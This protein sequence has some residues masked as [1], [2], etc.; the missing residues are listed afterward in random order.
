MIVNSLKSARPIFHGAA[1]L[2]SFSLL[3]G[4]FFSPALRAGLLLALHDGQ[5]FYWPNFSSPLTLWTDLIFGGFPIAADPQAQSWYPITRLLALIPDSWNAFMISAYVLASTLAYGYVYALTRSPL[6]A[7]VSGLTFGMSGFMIGHLPHASILH[8]VVWLPLMIWSLHEL[9]RGVSPGWVAAGAVGVALSALAGHPQLLVYCLVLTAA[10]ALVL[11]L[12]G[13]VPRGR[14]FARVAAMFVLGLALAAIQ[15]LPTFEL[16]A[17]ASRWRTD[18][19]MFSDVSLPPRQTI[20]LLFPYAFGGDSRSPYRTEY[21]GAPNQSE[22]A[23]YVG[24][25]P[26]VLAVAGLFAYRRRPV[27]WFWAVVAVLALW[28]AWGAATPLWRLIY[29][30]PMYNKFRAP[31]RHLVEFALAMSVLSGLGVAAILRRSQSHGPTSGDALEAGPNRKAMQRVVFGA[32][33]ILGFG[34]I[35][36][37]IAIGHSGVGERLRGR[38]AEETLLAHP[39]VFVPVLLLLV[40]VAALILWSRHPWGRW[41]Q[42]ILLIVL[43]ADLASFGFFNEWR[44]R[45]PNALEMA[46]TPQVTRYRE[47]LAESGQRLLGERGGAAYR[48]EFS[49]NL[50]RVWGVRSAGGYN[51]L[52][53]KRVSEFYPMNVY[54]AVDEPWAAD[55]NRSV[56]LMAVRYIVRPNREGTGRSDPQGAVRPN[57]QAAGGPKQEGTGRR[58]RDTADT[59][60][61]QRSPAHWLEVDRI[62]ERAIIYENLRA[63]PQAWMVAQV[64]RA[65][66][67]AVLRAIHTSLLPDGRSYDPREVALAEP[68]FPGER[69]A[70]DAHATVRVTRRRPTEL[71]LQT[72]ADRPG[73]MVLSDVYYPGWLARV[74]GRRTPLYQVNYVQRGIRVPSGTHEVR[75]EF[76]PRSFYAGMATSTASAVVLVLLLLHAVRAE[77]RARREHSQNEGPI[78]QLMT[79]QQQG[80]AK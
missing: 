19:G 14:Y 18:F 40:S 57:P 79:I 71:E 30:V 7:A 75:F 36:L 16:S 66:P 46:P 37:A 28:F 61:I 27:A 65:E 38:G 60:E 76:R 20:A 53:L 59:T 25:L 48:E 6:A 35:G 45:L 10:Y 63:M 78:R 72:H 21:F 68:P 67:R 49:L 55:A 13:G 56:D 51:Q 44:Y 1:V 80:K 62:G 3:Y 8:T 4:L 15:L 54:G 58:N 70:F 50:S 73:F 77:R 11:G 69:E 12:A 9:R 42:G 31:S 23:G 41:R 43:L 34:L 26:L 2:A 22:F 52:I 24:L 33:G 29:H 5:I 39:A 64:V 32:A 74:D 47:R 17:L